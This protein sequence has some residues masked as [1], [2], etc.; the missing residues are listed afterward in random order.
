MSSLLLATISAA[1]AENNIDE[2]NKEVQ[3]PVANLVNVPFQNNFN[4]SVGKN[5]QL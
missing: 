5:K 3:N 1:F 4:F 2:L